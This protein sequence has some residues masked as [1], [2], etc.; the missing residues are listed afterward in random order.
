MAVDGDGNIYIADTGDSAIK[1]W[2]PVSDQVTV[3]VSTGLKAPDGV[4]VDGQANV[5]IADTSDNAIKEFS[6]VYFS[7][8]A[9][10]RNEG[11]KAGTDSIPV[12][13]LPAGTPLTAVSSQSWLTITGTSGGAIAF[14]FKAN[15]SVSSRTAQ[16]TV[17]GLVAAVTQ[18]GDTPASI[19]KT[20][21]TGQSTAVSHAFATALE[22]RVTDA[23]GLGVQGANVTFTAVPGA[24]GADGT[25]GSSPPMPI[26]TNST[27]Y[28]TAPALTANSVAGTFTVTVS[29]GSLST[30]FTLTITK[31]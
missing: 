12:Q 25:F 7:L 10:S 31:Q 3:L 28:A 20:A 24:K 11:P 2:N 14:S 6:T 4:A 18:S 22:V 5:Y 29:V 16:I 26:P 27:G 30:T 17:S 21:G 15:T 8:G 23:A 1:Q 9:T 13:V 19:T